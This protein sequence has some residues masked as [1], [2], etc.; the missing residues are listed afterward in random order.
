MGKN[1]PPFFSVIMPVYNDAKHVGAALDSILAQ[2]DPDW[3]AV[4]V[5]D[6]STDATPDILKSYAEKD[7]RIRIF[8]KENGGAASA[9]N[10]GLRKA[11]GEWICWLSSDDLFDKRKLAVHREWISWKP[12]HRFF[13]TPFLIL[14]ETTGQIGNGAWWPAPDDMRWQVIEMLRGIYINAISIC[15]RREAFCAVGELDERL[16]YAQDYDVCLRLLAAHEAIR[17]P[18]RTCIRRNHGAQGTSAVGDACLFDSARAGIQFLNKRRFED[19]FPMLNLDDQATARAAL[20]KAMDVA[21]SPHSYLYAMGAHPALILRIMEWLWRGEDGLVPRDLKR[22]FRRRAWVCA[23]GH[24]GTALGA[25]WK[26]AALTA[27]IAECKIKYR[28]QD[29]ATVARMNLRLQMADGQQSCDCLRKY[30]ESFAGKTLTQ[31]QCAD[32]AKT[33]KALLSEMCRV[34][35][36]DAF[37]P[38]ENVPFASRLSIYLSRCKDIV[39]AKCVSA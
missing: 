22:L 27:Q 6:G 21:N 26:A 38:L 32:A 14:E 13:F 18:D 17:I 34:L 30:I 23:G 4:V 31:G 24:K 29:A 16:R 39:E 5:N 36:G 15:A 3:E 11:E 35:L 12:N 8:H 10:M 9:F 25:L 33:R 19:L 1:S 28:L 7:S 37:E 2:S 20:N